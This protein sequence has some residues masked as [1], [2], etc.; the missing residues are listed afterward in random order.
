MNYKRMTK[1][2]LIVEN[3]NMKYPVG[4]I[5]TLRKDDDSTLT[6]T[7]RYPAEVSASGHAVGWFTGVSGYYLL[8]RATPMQRDLDERRLG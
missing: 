4:T 7:T 6:T 1:A 5:V 2:D 8:E 3:W